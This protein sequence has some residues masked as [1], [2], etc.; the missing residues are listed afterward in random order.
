MGK[1]LE[2]THVWIITLANPTDCYFILLGAGD[3]SELNDGFSITFATVGWL[4][5]SRNTL[6][7]AAQQLQ[8]K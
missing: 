1:E 4:R 2:R 3:A 6:R 5:H 8:R 7:L